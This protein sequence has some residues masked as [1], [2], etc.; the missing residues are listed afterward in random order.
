MTNAFSTQLTPFNMYV[1]FLN[2]FR[3]IGIHMT[4]INNQSVKYTALRNSLKLAS[5]RGCLASFIGA[6]L[7]TGLIMLPS[8]F[9]VST[10][11][12]FF[13]SALSPGTLL[14]LGVGLGGALFFISLYALRM[15]RN[16]FIGKAINA[17]GV[18]SVAGVL[19]SILLYLSSIIVANLI[20]SHI[21]AFTSTTSGIFISLFTAGTFVYLL[22]ASLLVVGTLATMGLTVHHLL[23][24]I[25]FDKIHN[26]DWQ[27]NNHKLASELGGDPE[28]ESGAQVG[29]G[30]EDVTPS[31][32]GAPRRLLHH[33]NCQF[34]SVH[35]PTEFIEDF[36]RIDQLGNVITMAPGGL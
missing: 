14:G 33:F 30:T 13:L 8:H 24:F 10:V 7:S 20:A 26:D 32:P 16:D 4:T 25:F 19:G 31:R 9:G 2:S 5:Y 17:F 29:L 15:M 21:I 18:V 35:N 34:N 12:A 11:V 3:V 23:D 36:E 6:L 27:D 22:A 28:Q 1:N